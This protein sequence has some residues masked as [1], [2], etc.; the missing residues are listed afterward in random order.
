M[1]GQ[2][3]GRWDKTLRSVPRKVAVVVVGLSLPRAMSRGDDSAKSRVLSYSKTKTDG[4][5]FWAEKGVLIL[6]PISPKAA[7]NA[8]GERGI[9]S[10]K[11]SPV[12]CR[13]IRCNHFDTQ[14]CKESLSRV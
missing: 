13:V 1:I 5:P 6:M 8:R 14:R 7:I 9:G 3:N 12:I 2:A 4:S 10:G 11:G